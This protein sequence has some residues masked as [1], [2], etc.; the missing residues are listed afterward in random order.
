[1]RQ[2]QANAITDEIT[3]ADTI[4]PVRILNSKLSLNDHGLSVAYS[5]PVSQAFFMPFEPDGDVVKLWTRFD[6]GGVTVTD[7]SC[8]KNEIEIRHDDEGNAPQPQL[9]MTVED[10]GVAKNKISSY[11]QKSKKHYFRVTDPQFQLS[12]NEHFSFF[13]KI[14]PYSIS[15]NLDYGKRAVLLDY[16][17]NDQVSHAVRV[18]LDEAGF[19]YFFVRWNYVDYFVKSDGPVII[20]PDLE[21]YYSEDF[22]SEDYSTS[23]QEE[24]DAIV[25]GLTAT[26]MSYIFCTFNKDTK[27][28]TIL[29]PTL[30]E[31]DQEIVETWSSN[32]LAVPQTSNLSMWLPLSQGGS[33]TLKDISGLNNHGSFDSNT[34]P[35]K[36][37]WITS[38]TRRF[39]EFDTDEYATIPNSTSLNTLSTFSI[40]FFLNTD[41][42][43]TSQANVKYLF[44]KDVSTFGNGAFRITN[45]AGSSQTLSF[46]AKNN[47]G[48]TRTIDVTNQIQPSSSYHIVV[49][50]DGTNYKIY[51]NKTLVNTTAF[52]S[53]VFTNSG[54]L[55]IG[56][57]NATNGF[58]GNVSNI[59]FWKG[60]ALSQSEIDNLYDS[61]LAY[62]YSTLDTVD[63]GPPF[64]RYW[65]E[66]PAPPAPGTP[67]TLPFTQTLYDQQSGA[68]FSAVRPVTVSG[69]TQVYSV[70]GGTPV[71][72]PVVLQY[73]VAPGIVTAG[74][75]G[76]A[77]TTIYDLAPA[78]STGD[79][80]DTEFAYG[81]YIRTTSSVLY[82]K[83]ITEITVYLK[84]ASASGGTLNI[85]IIKANGTTIA[86]GTAVPLSGAGGL[87]S[88][89]QTFVRANAA[90]TYV[91][92]VGDA[93]GIFW[94][95][96][97]S[98]AINIQR[99]GSGT[100]FENSAYSCQAVHDGTSW[101]T[102]NS[103]F[104]M[105][106]IIKTG[107][108]GP[109]AVDPY[110]QI[111][112]GTTTNYAVGESF[113]SGSPMVGITPTKIE[114]RVY[115]HASATGTIYIK[116]VDNSNVLKATL[117]TQL[118]SGLPT[119]A[120]TTFN[121]VWEDLTYA[122]PIAVNDKIIVALSGGNSNPIYVLGNEGATGTP[123]SYDGTR[124]C[125][126]YRKSGDPGVPP[127]V[128]P[129]AESWNSNT[130]RDISG[131][132]W[133]GGNDFTGYSDL[134]NTRKRTGIK[135]DTAS[136]SF[137]GKKVT[138]VTATLKKVGTPAAGA[139]YCRIRNSA[140]TLRETI[141]QTDISAVST[142]DT[143]IDFVNTTH[144]TT[145]ALDDTISIEYD[146]GD[147]SN[148]VAVRINK[149]QFETINTILFE[150][151][152]ASINTATAV[153]DRDLAAVIYTGGETD[154]AAR[155]RVGLSVNNSNSS[156]WGKAITKVRLWLKREGSTFAVDDE[157]S[158][159]IIRG[160][161]KATVSTLGTMEILDLTTSDV[162]YD[163]E[164]VGNSYVMADGDMI[165]VENLFG[166][167]SNYVWVKRSATQV[168]D[169]TS[170]CLIDWN[171]TAYN[172]TTDQDLNMIAWT[173]GYTIYPDPNIP[174]PPTPYH[175][176]HEMFFGSST[177]PDSDTLVLPSTLEPDSETMFDFI[178]ADFRLY[179]GK[180]IAEEEALNLFINKYTISALAFS[181]VDTVAHSLVGENPP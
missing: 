132:I 47:G 135:V 58:S 168:I 8:F 91:M 75:G 60:V 179:Q 104:S 88:S 119:T 59:M 97:S 173:G 87:T 123:S 166:N 109:P 63:N 56:H 66:P 71:T 25:L 4:F 171:S 164:N 133:S 134:N 55:Y 110:L 74:G 42:D 130:A 1:M 131:K 28:S 98:G 93:V 96:G 13:F 118:V 20:L 111:K 121:L 100:H 57:P 84:S 12:D 153:N 161:D 157:F 83:A 92:A 103:S 40:S 145:L 7:Y 45:A 69:L 101:G 142:S 165:V 33:T 116:H 61:F 31:D 136:S 37:D 174:T 129:T 107:T 27:I 90:N 14:L 82:N 10:D 177:T 9:L 68:A 148:Y 159:K 2:N 143:S 22:F 52:S 65:S 147:A 94:T 139:I 86:F 26:G 106:G 49:T 21:D 85:G 140:G 122:V 30:D 112:T 81:Q 156:L 169:D 18:E 67:I 43:W 35:Q 180:E 151:L 39:L 46:V 178:A 126:I 124:T 11:L 6:S 76:G 172:L 54:N 141:N 127:F 150:S 115:R 144:N 3:D 160:S 138:K 105:A 15:N 53:D 181:E 80:D 125:V 23:S 44:G 102:P 154:T 19:L 50:Y 41:S 155:P 24:D 5:K 163:F 146:L 77:V 120:P 36:P 175:Y 158:V 108:A 48:T 38:G 70:A 79:I 34:D 29:H 152:A 170:T 62:Y 95:G 32:P 117:L 128:P 167:A 99:G 78:S 16:I 17:E 72:D 162:A 114:L 149:N 73:D 113:P 51:N 176:S 64:P 137:V 89:Y